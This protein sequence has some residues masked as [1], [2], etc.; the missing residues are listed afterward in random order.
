MIAKRNELSPK[1]RVPA[2][3]VRIDYLDSQ[4]PSANDPSSGLL[5]RRDRLS[6]RS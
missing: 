6:S 4:I 1:A 2:E 5:L 3:A